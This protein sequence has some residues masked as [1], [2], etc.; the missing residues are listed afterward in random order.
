MHLPFT[1]NIQTTLKPTLPQTHRYKTTNLHSIIY[2][3]VCGEVHSMALASTGIQT[4]KGDYRKH[5]VFEDVL[6]RAPL[7]CQTT[8]RGVGSHRSLSVGGRWTSWAGWRPLSSSVWRWSGRGQ[9]G[10]WAGSPSSSAGLC[11]PARSPGKAGR[12]REPGALS[13]SNMCFQ[14]EEGRWGQKGGFSPFFSLDFSFRLSVKLAGGKI[15]MWSIVFL[16]IWQTHAS[17]GLRNLG[18][19]VNPILGKQNIP[20]LAN[21]LTNNTVTFNTKYI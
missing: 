8:D 5:V 7:W 20:I 2:E 15:Q 10:M 6:I 21:R 16:S 4:R 9:P 3:C 18:V 17:R 11:T 19:Y 12:S 1:S 13:Y 14:T